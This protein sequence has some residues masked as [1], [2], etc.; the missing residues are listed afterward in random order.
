MKHQHTRTT[1]RPGVI[2]PLT[3]VLLIPLL[4]LIAFSVDLG[5]LVQVKAEL[6][7]VADAAALAGA[8]ALQQPYTL[9][10]VA[11]ADKDRLRTNAMTAARE[12][13]RSYAGYNRAGNT[14]LTLRDDDIAFG[15]LDSD[16]RYSETLTSLQYPNSVRVTLR[17][18]R[19]SNGLVG[20]FFAPVLGTSSVA[21]TASSRATIY[22]GR[23]D[24]FRSIPGFRGGMLPMTYDASHWDAFVLTGLDPDGNLSR[25]A[26]GTPQIQV[27]PSVKY[28]G[29]FGQLALDDE[30]A[31]ASEI[32]DWI[33]NGIDAT[34][35]RTLQSHNLIPISNH[36]AN[37][38][39]WLG[40]PG[41]KS[42]TVEAANQYAGETYL[43]PLYQ[44]V[45]SLPAPFYE[46]GVG[47]GEEYNYNIVRFVPIK[48]MPADRPNRE[49]VV[50]PS[51]HVDPTAV[52][53]LSTI[54][55]AGS[56]A[57]TLPTRTTFT[58]AKLTE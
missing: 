40:D 49:I 41:F 14:T 46:A 9:W 37:T 8:Q 30:H 54:A 18:D 19:F 29:N 26:D 15:F 4:G 25:A 58:T 17:R 38:W 23:I 45:R 34:T 5:Y 39:D 35:I 44:A 56:V 16:G 52:F 50:Q 32:R 7:H 27:Y 3:A 12:A 20:L 24:G 21:L 2:A 42:S 6:Q 55:P 11:T 10:V 53:D 43:L 57:E 13:A 28:A 1:R 22:T 36:P 33:A 51:G 31:G 47:R 48:I